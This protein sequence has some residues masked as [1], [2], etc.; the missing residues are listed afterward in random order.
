VYNFG[1]GGVLPR[2]RILWFEAKTTLEFESRRE[3]ILSSVEY[4]TLLIGLQGSECDIERFKP[5]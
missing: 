4:G 2:F 5:K 1:G 3:R